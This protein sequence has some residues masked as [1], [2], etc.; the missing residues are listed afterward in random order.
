MNADYF[1]EIKASTPLAAAEKLI[2][3]EEKAWHSEF[4]ASS[5]IFKDATTTN[6]AQFRMRPHGA[7]NEFKL[8]LSSAPAPGGFT[9]IWPIGAAQ[10]GAMLLE[11]NLAIV[12]AYRKQ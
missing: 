5:I 4:I 11:G 2:A 3:D 6:A 1:I 10:S 9:R 8:L 12:A 7:P